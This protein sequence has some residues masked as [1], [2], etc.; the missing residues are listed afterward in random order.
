MTMTP[1]G[2]GPAAEAAATRPAFDLWVA[3]DSPGEIELGQVLQQ[4]WAAVGMK[5]N[6]RAEADADALHQ[7]TLD[8]ECDAWL[9]LHS[10]IDPTMLDLVSQY[11]ET[12]G[13]SNSTTTR[14]R[15]STS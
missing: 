4:Q 8:G 2:Q 9:S 7:L 6:I 10:P 5:V 14:T 13:A 12:A 1:T 3:S 11:Y 15:R